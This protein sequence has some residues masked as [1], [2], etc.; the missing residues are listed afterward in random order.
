MSAEFGAVNLAPYPFT[1]IG[2]GMTEEELGDLAA[3]VHRIDKWLVGDVD[4]DG[5]PKNGLI[6]KV[7]RVLIMQGWQN[8]VL[9][10]IIIVLLVGTLPD[11][12]RI[13]AP[14]FKMVIP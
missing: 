10:A 8:R 9:A 11:L 13:W 4:N 5:V 12:P 1:C 6:S 14:V 2:G 7:N 3:S